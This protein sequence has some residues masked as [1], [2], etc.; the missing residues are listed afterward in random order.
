MSKSR[1]LASNNGISFRR[2]MRSQPGPWKPPKF[3]FY[4]LRSAA[5]HHTSICYK[6]HASPQTLYSLTRPRDNSSRAS[7]FSLCDSN[8]RC[9][10]LCVSVC[11][12]VCAIQGSYSKHWYHKHKVR[13]NFCSFFVGCAVCRRCVCITPS[14][15]LFVRCG[16]HCTTAAAFQGIPFVTAT[17]GYV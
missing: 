4:V 11:V 2:A 17:N 14:C 12:S 13:Y 9:F 3:Y 7:S 1:D 15:K 10:C 5:V 16:N 8:E 6:Y